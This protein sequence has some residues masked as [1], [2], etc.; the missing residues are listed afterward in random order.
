MTNAEQSLIDRF[1]SCL[2][3]ARAERWEKPFLDPKRF[4]SNQLRTRGW[5]KL[6]PGEQRTIET[7]Y[8]RSFTVVT[9]EKV[10]EQI[11]SYGVYEPELTE[12][13]LR[14]VRPGQTVL[15]IGMHLGYYA[16]LFAT[17]VGSKGS[18]HAFEPTPSTRQLAARN[19]AL[20]PQITL[21]PEAV[22][23]KNETLTFRDYGIDWM[24]FN[25]FT[26]A[27]MAG[28][29]APREFSVQTVTLDSFRATLGQRISLIKIDAESAEAQIIDGAS[30]LLKMDQPLLSLEVGDLGH[31]SAGAALIKLLQQQS[32]E[33]WEFKRGQFARH[34]IA[35]NYSYD[36]LI[37]AP[38]AAD[39]TSF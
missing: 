12:A 13:F 23:N 4:L 28:A 34:Q 24:A 20:F 33:P 39:L 10:S 2:R 6:K 15:D 30:A 25:S 21:H 22:W 14:L 29:P 3:Y 26:E 37:F 18:V 38:R 9:G 16:T 11:A 27:K 5:T 19:I 1:H 31:Q 32:Y 8:L 17:L 35:Q 7:F 36:N